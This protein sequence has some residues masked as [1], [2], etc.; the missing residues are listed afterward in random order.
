MHLLYDIKNEQCKDLFDLIQDNFLDHHVVIYDMQGFLEDS[1]KR[2]ALQK[3]RKRIAHS[4][5]QYM[6]LLEALDGLNL[7]PSNS[8]GRA[9]RKSLV[10]RIHVGDFNIG[11]FYFS[12]I[13]E[14]WIWKDE[15][16]F[17]LKQHL[18]F[19]PT[20]HIHAHI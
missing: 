6:K 8:G 11:L 2:P 3:S 5:E 13:L 4:T 18:F 1:L 14:L 10:D 20:T 15:L 17:S 19:I 9:K 16:V 12:K 7:D